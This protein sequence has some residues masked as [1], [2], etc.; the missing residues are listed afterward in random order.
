MDVAMMAVAFGAQLVA[1]VSHLFEQ[2]QNIRFGVFAAELF[3]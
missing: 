2:R 1:E 3:E